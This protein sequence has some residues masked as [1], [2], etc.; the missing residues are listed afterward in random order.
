MV[1][2]FGWLKG[3]L[4]SARRL[5]AAQRE[6]VFSDMMTVHLCY[7]VLFTVSRRH[8]GAREPA[9]RRVGANCIPPMLAY[10]I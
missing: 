9:I 6:I 3:Q 2:C 5:I 7:F 10:F 4:V 8:V 1:W